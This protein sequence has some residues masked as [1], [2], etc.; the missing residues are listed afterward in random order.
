MFLLF[1]VTKYLNGQKMFYYRY[2]VNLRNSI[3]IHSVFHDSKHVNYQTQYI[4]L[5]F[6]KKHIGH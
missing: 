6:S 1:S 2:R 4:V 3:D 5:S